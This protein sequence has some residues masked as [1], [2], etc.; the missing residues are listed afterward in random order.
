MKSLYTFVVTCSDGSEDVSQEY[1]D[2]LNDALDAWSRNIKTD[3]FIE[4]LTSHE[5]RELAED[6]SAADPSHFG[7][8]LPISGLEDVWRVSTAL[9]SGKAL[10]V[11]CVLSNLNSKAEQ[12]GDP[13]T[14]QRPCRKSDSVVR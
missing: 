4:S 10:I 11:T 13:D 1:G 8:A 14:L 9:R 3:G 7:E 12:V 5:R 2:T 6:F